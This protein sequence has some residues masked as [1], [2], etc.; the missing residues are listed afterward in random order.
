MSL[1]MAQNPTKTKTSKSTWIIWQIL[2]TRE[3]SEVSLCLRYRTGFSYQLG[4]A[5]EKKEKGPWG[6]TEFTDHSSSYQIQAYGLRLIWGYPFK[7]MHGFGRWPVALEVG[8]S[9]IHCDQSEDQ[10]CCLDL[11]RS[12]AELSA[13]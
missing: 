6:Q 10:L 3:V 7:W 4:F 13:R 11:E 2:G 5:E 1:D 8:A 9:I 12:F